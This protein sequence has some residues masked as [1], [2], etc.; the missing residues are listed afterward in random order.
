MKYARKRVFTDP[1]SPVESTI[2]SLYGRIRV[3][4]NLYSR[5]FYAVLVNLSPEGVEKNLH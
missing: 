5:I 1:Y 2:L 3:I 4:E